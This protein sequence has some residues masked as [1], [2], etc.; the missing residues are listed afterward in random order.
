MRDRGPG[1]PEHYLERVFERYVR[2]PNTRD[3]SGGTGIGLAIAHQVAELHRGEIEAANE[4]DGG[5]TFTVCIPL[6][7][8]HASE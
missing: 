3:P 6:N 4:P 5:C 8:E 2:V 7:G 1:I